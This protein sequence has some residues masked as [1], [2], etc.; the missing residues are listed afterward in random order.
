MATT[1]IPDAY[2]SIR[3]VPPSKTGSVNT[4]SS[5]LRVA[6][7]GL[8]I[9]FATGIAG[10]LS[11]N[12]SAQSVWDQLKA[13]AKKATQPATASRP[14]QPATAA[15]PGQPAAAGKTGQPA[16]SAVN[17]GTGPFTPPAGTGIVPTVV[18]PFYQGSQYVIS[19]Q[20]VH[21]ATLTNSGSRWV[22]ILDGVEGPK[23]DQVFGQ[24]SGMSG[25]KFSP[26]GNHYVYCALSGNEFVLMAD[27]KEIFR[28]SK[29]NMQGAINDAS[30]AGLTFSANS[31][32]FYFTSQGRVSNSSSDAFRFV[33]DGQASP[34]GADNDYRN[35]GFSP[36]GNHFA[37]IWTDPGNQGGSQRLIVDGKPAS[38]LGQQLQWSPDSEHLYVTHRI[39]GARPEVDIL[40]DG[41]TVM[42]ADDITLYLPATGNL[43]I[44]RITKISG[45]PNPY[46]FLV[47][48]GK[49]V[50]GS[51]PGRS[52][53]GDIHFSP[54]GK[55]YASIFVDNNGHQSIFSDGKRSQTYSR[56]DPFT[57]LTQGESGP[58]PQIAFTGD[59]SKVV[60]VGDNASGLQFL[61]IGDQE[62]APIR[63]LTFVSIAPVGNHVLAAGAGQMVLDGKM[64]PAVP[65]QIYEPLMGP[66]GTHYAFATRD[67]GAINIYLDGVEQT[68]YGAIENNQNIY[69]FSPDGQH[70][71][72][73]CTSKNSAAGNDVGVCLDGKYTSM[74]PA[75][76]SLMNLTF[77]ADS[78][79]L[80]WIKHV[81]GSGFRMYADG[82]P[83]LDGGLPTVGGFQKEAWQ[84][85][86]K[87]G[88]VILT[89]DGT[90][91][92][93]VAIT[94]SSSTSLATMLGA[95]TTT[96]STR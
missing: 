59:G 44:A 46:Q 75:S 21:L 54:D 20:G 26:D 5:S 9:V 61:V 25:V 92:K 40:M 27:G 87:G 56:L 28:D 64:L 73:F 41:K 94:P 1:M 72:Y 76:G 16:A 80:F 3:R 35:Y 90:S 91:F 62:S 84:T 11:P 63:G 10:G 85:D 60:Y 71:A 74:G 33:W 88:M 38:Y 34:L 83:V 52:G 19:P 69:T 58:Q 37:Y 15:R 50:P 45:T 6:R 89:Q 24:S 43:G 12:A 7:L 42:R 48:G 36:D 79:H 13:Q 51:N 55:H 23:F 31:K 39:G 82:K 81:G 29:T 93:R 30:C 49:E 22:I 96:A 8:L 67:A 66:D 14:G 65:G 86:G 32:H 53:V 4:L 95:G 18:G 68:A 2:E 78:N 57:L 77:S 47:I 17:N 70:I